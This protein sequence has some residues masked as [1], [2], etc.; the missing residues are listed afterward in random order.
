[1]MRKRGALF[2]LLAVLALS[3]GASG[4]GGGGDRSA[5][6]VHLSVTTHLGGKKTTKSFTLGCDP[7]SGSLPLAARVC[8]DIATHRQA[9]LAPRPARSTCGG[10]PF[11]PVV[12]VDVVKGADGSS[13]SG[14]PNCGWP[15]GTPL[16][17]YW[18]ASSRDER[19]LQRDSARLRCEDDPA[20]F[21]KP[22][23]WASI[24]ACTHGLWTSA[25]ERAIRRAETAPELALLR[26]VTLFPHDPGVV[27]CRIPA[28]GPTVRVF[29]GL[30]GVSLTG[31]PSTKLVHFVET[32]AEG[33]HIFRHHW[34][35]HGS[36]LIGQRGAVPPQLWM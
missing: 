26:P 34:T 31:P 15:G 7:V 24:N 29:Y 4:C 9:M 35:L 21:A 27:R 8:R 30:C 28:G 20:F 1:M 19:A 18:D 33:G 32:W 22:T 5:V 3:L 16:A 6:Q 2:V 36:T 13:F 10:S 14:M 23:P 25:A 17:V 12:E 11:A